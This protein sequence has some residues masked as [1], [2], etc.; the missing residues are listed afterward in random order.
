MN[1]QSQSIFFN[2]LPLQSVNI[3]RSP[4]SNK[5]A[6]TLYDI[7]KSDKDVY[8]KFIV[9]DDIDSFQV[10]SLKT[11][12]YV[13]APDDRFNIK[14]SKVPYVE[15]TDKG[16]QVIRNIILHTEKSAL[17]K[18]SEVINYEAIYARL[19]NN[20]SMKEAKTAS[21]I[22]EA[23]KFKNW[24]RKVVGEDRRKVANYKNGNNTQIK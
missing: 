18:S 6:Q 8:G 17:D 11:K 2:F 10:S 7:W 12:G 19:D 22:T 9:S 21:S 4:L 13:R 24:L 16:K 14:E 15:I 3:S 23:K 1:K 20:L 5:E